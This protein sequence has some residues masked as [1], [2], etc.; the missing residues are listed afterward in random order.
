VYVDPPPPP[1]VDQVDLTL[2]VAVTVTF[3]SGIVN[4][5]FVTAIVALLESFTDRFQNV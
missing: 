3:D 5:L 2:K 4:L 1:E